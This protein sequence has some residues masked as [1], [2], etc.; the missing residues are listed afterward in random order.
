[1]GTQ[2]G[3]WALHRR[4]PQRRYVP[5]SQRSTGQC[6][7]R[8]LVRDTVLGGTSPPKAPFVIGVP[9]PSGPVGLLGE[10]KYIGHERPQQ[11]ADSGLS[12]SSKNSVNYSSVASALVNS[13]RKILQ[14]T[15]RT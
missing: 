11:Q 9:G 6:P 5:S 1:M 15:A 14:M 10:K 3:V 4:S 13:F 8:T 7:A 2:H 12:N